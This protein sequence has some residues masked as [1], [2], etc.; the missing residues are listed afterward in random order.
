MPELIAVVDELPT[1]DGRSLLDRVREAG[2]EV[3]WTFSLGD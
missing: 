1:E 3:V 2:T